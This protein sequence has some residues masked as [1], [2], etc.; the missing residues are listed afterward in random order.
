MRIC[1]LTRVKSDPS[2]E[3]RMAPY[4]S[5]IFREN[6][7]LATVRFPIESKFVPQAANFRL[8]RILLKNSFLA[9]HLNFAA[10]LSRQYKKDVGGP[11]V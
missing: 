11:V 9:A 1:A 2:G 5:A 8:W 6:L 10:P 7:D 4:N 3:G